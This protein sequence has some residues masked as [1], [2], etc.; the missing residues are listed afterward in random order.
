VSRRLTGGG[1]LTLI[2][3]MAGTSLFLC[4]WLYWSGRRRKRRARK[5]CALPTRPVRRNVGLCP[6][7]QMRN[8]RDRVELVSCYC[9]SCFSLHG[10]SLAWTTFL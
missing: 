1:K 8:F 10:C 3:V 4:S 6:E 9:D 7:G 5:S 2:R